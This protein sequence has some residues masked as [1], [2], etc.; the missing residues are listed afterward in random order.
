MVSRLGEKIHDL[1]EKNENAV[2]FYTQ[3]VGKNIDATNG[4]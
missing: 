4:H 2:K 3:T 1:M